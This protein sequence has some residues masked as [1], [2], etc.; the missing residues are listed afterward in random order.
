MEQQPITQPAT[1]V[2]QQPKTNRA[3]I[4]I[5][6]GIIVLAIVG[7]AILFLWHFKIQNKSQNIVKFSSSI[8]SPA[9]TIPETA[10]QGDIQIFNIGTFT[11]GQYQNKNLTLAIF[12]YSDPGYDYGINN[13]AYYISDTKGNPVVWD[14]NY[15]HEQGL[16]GNDANTPPVQM[17]DLIG[18][19]KNLQQSLNFLPAELSLTKV[20][21]SNNHQTLFSIT[22]DNI[23]A[24]NTIVGS[25][26]IATTESGFPIV[27]QMKADITTVL[28]SASYFVLLPFGEAIEIAPEP[29]FINA[30]DVPQLKWTTGTSTVA[31]YRYGQ[32]AYGWEDCYDGI[33]TNQLNTSLVQT[34]N[35]TNGSLVYEVDAQKYPNVYKCL[36]E[37]TKTY[38]WDDVTKTGSYQDTVSYADF[39]L[40]HP[41]FFWKHSTGDWIAFVRSDVVPAAEK[42]KPVI[43]L[44]PEKS[45]QVNVRV[46]PIGGLVKTDPIYENGWTV[47]ATPD[48][49]LTDTKTGKEY[50]YL[51]WEGG[52]DGVV[53]VSKQGFV[54]AKK[55]V[56]LTLT[57][58]LS[59]FGLNK[60]EQD[61][62]LEFWVPK[63]SN[64]PYYF[65]TFISRSE[66][67]RVSPMNINP[68]PDTVIRVLMDYVPLDKPISAEPLTITP[69]ERKGFTVVEWGG[70]LIK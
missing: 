69:A 59:E 24:T 1:P 32:Y 35:T 27:K 38:I 33:S 40:S 28:P 49:I 12:K 47:N 3:F 43:Y 61:D 68:K 11:Q 56:S 34:G 70:I 46:N 8:N 55:D 15:I 10:Y 18:L 50:P 42:A 9:K 52:K 37:K 31:S 30:Q 53:K 14:P 20:I 36:H 41:M 29:D 57:Q 44:Y 60:K 63:L 54:V 58:K 7:G 19:T 39:I 64:A 45:E 25:T 51:F 26:S 66:I 22:S 4:F 6:I 2:F 65:I 48:S 17:N 67:D 23:V 16:Y 62:F 21:K 13:Y 5:L